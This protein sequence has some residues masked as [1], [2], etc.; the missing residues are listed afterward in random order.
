M[1]FPKTLFA[2][3]VAVVLAVSSAVAADKFGADRHVARGV[4]CQVCHGKDMNN[5]QYPDEKTCT[6]C[7]PK[8][9]V[10]KKSVDLKP[11]PHVAPHNGDCTLCHMMHEP[12]VNYCS[13]CHDFKFPAVP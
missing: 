11:N 1:S 7:H 8:D 5:P 9:A 13:Q 3:G 12:T 10:A 4:A 2:A 6:Q